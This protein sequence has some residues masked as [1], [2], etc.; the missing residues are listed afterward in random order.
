MAGIGWQVIH[1]HNFSEVEVL[2]LEIYN[3]RLPLQEYNDL[4]EGG[5]SRH[6]FITCVV[7]KPEPAGQTADSQYLIVSKIEFISQRHPVST[8]Q[9]GNLGSFGK[10]QFIIAAEH[11]YIHRFNLRI[12]GIR[13][14]HI[15][16]VNEA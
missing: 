16:V 15:V 6:Q 8:N 3:V 7:R 13:I 11:K 1:F 14:F 5:C 12:E 4:L 9:R 10:E 2:E